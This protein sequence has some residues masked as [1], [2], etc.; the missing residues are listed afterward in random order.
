MPTLTLYPNEDVSVTMS[1]Y[2][3]GTGNYGRINETTQ[4]DRTA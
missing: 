4:D 1:Q 2:G 3:S